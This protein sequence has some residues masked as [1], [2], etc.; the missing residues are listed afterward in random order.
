MHY[1]I[2]VLKPNGS[3]DHAHYAGDGRAMLI[4]ADTA[5]EAHD[6]A[7]ALTVPSVRATLTP[8]NEPANGRQTLRATPAVVMGGP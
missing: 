7:M 3:L 4:W 6:K 2:E 5:R 8:W 1:L